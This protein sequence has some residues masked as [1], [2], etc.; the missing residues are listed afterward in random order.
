MGRD[1]ELGLQYSTPYDTTE[2]VFVAFTN[3]GVHVFARA[4]WRISGRRL[5]VVPRDRVE[6]AGI[7]M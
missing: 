2:L 7:P 4:V 5:N 6:A 3:P 1:M